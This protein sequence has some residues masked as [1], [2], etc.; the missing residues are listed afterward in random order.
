MGK[1]FVLFTP[2]FRSA[3][4]MI[5]K[6]VML[7]H[8]SCSRNFQQ[9]SRWFSDRIRR[10]HINHSHLVAPMSSTLS[11]NLK[12]EILT[13]HLSTCLPRTNIYLFSRL[14]CIIYIW[15][16]LFSPCSSIYGHFP[17]MALA[18]IVIFSSHIR[19]LHVH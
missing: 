2:Q 13:L 16:F 19:A 9:R 1:L 10:L 15:A 17:N 3:E 18:F 8:K 4:L 5:K 12:L 14:F 7:N 11:R 6:N